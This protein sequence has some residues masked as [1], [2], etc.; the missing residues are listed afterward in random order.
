MLSVFQARLDG[1][2]SASVAKGYSRFLKNILGNELKDCQQ[3]D[4]KTLSKNVDN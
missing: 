4:A 3:K 1:K 2:N